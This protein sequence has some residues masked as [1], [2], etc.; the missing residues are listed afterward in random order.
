MTYNERVQPRPRGTPTRRPWTERSHRP[1][2]ATGMTVGTSRKRGCHHR[3]AGWPVVER[4]RQAADERRI[5]PIFLPSHSACRTGHRWSLP[6][7]LFWWSVLGSPSGVVQEQL[8]VSYLEQRAPIAIPASSDE[9]TR[10]IDLHYRPL[11]LE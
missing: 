1:L 7:R 9:L 8:R 2:D 11:I 3:S 10:E 4:H 5:V 6:T